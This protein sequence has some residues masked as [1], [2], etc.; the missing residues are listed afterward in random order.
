[1]TAQIHEGLIFEGEETSMA[2]CPP[3]PGPPIPRG[4][5]DADTIA[6]LLAAFDAA[7]AGGWVGHPRVRQADGGEGGDL[8]R[9]TACCR[10]Y[11]GTWQIKDGRFYL[12]GLKG[13]YRLDGDEP[14]FADWFT[15]VL[16][17]PRGKCLHYVHMGFASVYEQ[18]V[19]VQVEKGVVVGTRVI[20]NRGKDGHPARDTRKTQLG[21]QHMPGGENYVPGDEGV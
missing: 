15:G 20:D 6:A 4:L 7:R 17:I 2:C 3:L 18:E 9:S 21:L 8:P 10:G 1:M 5:S 19:H 14:L 11:R 13:K 12:V 16:R